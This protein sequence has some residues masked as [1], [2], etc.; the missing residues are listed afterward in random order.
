M[1]SVP[2]E[3]SLPSVNEPEEADLVLEYIRSDAE[4]HELLARV[5]AGSPRPA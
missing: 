1:I 2:V 5:V 4:Q 3:P